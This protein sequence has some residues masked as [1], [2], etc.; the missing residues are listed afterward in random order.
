M[1]TRFFRSLLIFAAAF[2]NSAAFAHDAGDPSTVN[3]LP[4]TLANLPAQTILQLADVVT[5]TA[6]FQDVEQAKREQYADIQV[7]VPHMGHHYMRQDIVD[8]YFDPE[9]P[10][11]L[12]YADDPCT[13]G[14][15]LVA[16]EYAIPLDQSKNMPAGF[17][18]KLDVW[19]ANAGF[20]LWLLHAWVWKY[21]P[22]GVFAP[23]NPTVE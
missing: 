7:D 19:D 4:S 17:V 10:E 11:L 2:V 5:A 15:T 22:D 23:L 20:G 14:L 21:N 1:K 16:V 6:R 8:A 13:G 3:T 9:H 18:G 12:V